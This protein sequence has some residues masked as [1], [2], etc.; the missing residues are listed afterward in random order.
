[1]AL[2]TAFK[3]ADLPARGFVVG[4]SS[5]DVAVA[6]LQLPGAIKASER[7]GVLRTNQRE[8]S[9]ALPLMTSAVSTQLLHTE[10]SAENTMMDTLMAAVAARAELDSIVQVCKLARAT[11]R[12]VDLS[13]AAT[14]RALVRCAPDST[15][16]ATI[17]DIGASKTSVVTRQGRYLRSL[18][19]LGI[20]GN[21]FTRAIVSATKDDVTA[22][23]RRKLSMRLDTLRSVHTLTPTSYIDA[24]A[25]Q[26]QD[27]IS[28]T[29]FEEAVERVCN[30]L[31]DQIQDAI[32]QD[33]SV[34]DSYPQ[35]IIMAGGGSLMGGLKERLS[36]RLGIQTQIGRPWAVIERNR[37]TETYF[38]G[39][40][41]DATV[42]QSLSTAIGLGLW[43]EPR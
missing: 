36:Q 34:Y 5:P 38:T 15:D 9:P 8:I 30:T 7:E 12:A 6:Q 16:V 39:A 40:T 1:L 27:S 18:R 24:P 43:T 23:E 28:Q 2:A 4:L 37:K 31:L 21:D 13:G 25:A 3:D 20:G 35:G 11:P 19:V 22:A 26:A 10:L 41:E 33:A 42:L 14:L 32:D 29:D 17:I